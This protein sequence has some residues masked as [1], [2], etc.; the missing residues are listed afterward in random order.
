MN[1]LYTAFSIKSSK[2]PL[3][4][5]DLNLS[6]PLEMFAG[7]VH[8]SQV[9]AFNLNVLFV[10]RHKIKSRSSDLCIAVD[11]LVPFSDHH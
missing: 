9:P 5:I 4:E 10:P 1:N 7:I 6:C 8:R 11:H 2:V 3:Q